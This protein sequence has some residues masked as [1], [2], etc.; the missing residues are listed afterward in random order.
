M[1]SEVVE[2]VSGPILPT[3]WVVSHDNIS[4]TWVEFILN[5]VASDATGHLPAGVPFSPYLTGCTT[6]VDIS[7]STV[8]SSN[9]EHTSFEWYS[10]FCRNGGLAWL[11]L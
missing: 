2:S 11:I 6:R 9:S 7:R 1:Y 8:G 10:Y 3:R 5:F 4:S